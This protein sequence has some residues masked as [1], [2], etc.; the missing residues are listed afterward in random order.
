MTQCSRTFSS[1][2]MLARGGEKKTIILI[3]N[4]NV[5]PS[6]FQMLKEMDSSKTKIISICCFEGEVGGQRTLLSTLF[7]IGTNLLDSAVKKFSRNQSK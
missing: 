2:L 7:L 1:I 3:T 4:K 6:A 5:Y